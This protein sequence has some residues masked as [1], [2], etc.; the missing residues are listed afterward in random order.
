MPV[1][2]DKR[3]ELVW[4]TGDMADPS[5][6]GPI[7]AGASMDLTRNASGHPLVRWG[8]QV[9]EVDVYM[10]PGEPVY[11]HLLCPKCRNMLTISATRKHIEYDKNAGDPKAGGRLNVETFMCTWDGAEGRRMD[12][13]LGLCAWKVAIDNNVARNA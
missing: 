2:D 12:F 9:L 13:G 11:L 6:Q 3:E 10:L 5:G 4:H 1:Y 7:G 8:D